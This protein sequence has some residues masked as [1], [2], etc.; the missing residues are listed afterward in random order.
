MLVLEIK[1]LPLGNH[2]LLDSLAIDDLEFGG[3]G[4]YITEVLPHW[5]VWVV[6]QFDGDTRE[7]NEFQHMWPEIGRQSLNNK[8]YKM[9]SSLIKTKIVF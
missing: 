7:R 1:Q 5:Y 2:S 3:G 6:R 9:D 4:D 8:I